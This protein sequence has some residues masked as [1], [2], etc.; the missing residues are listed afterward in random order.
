MGLGDELALINERYETTAA[1]VTRLRT[2]EDRYA[3]KLTANQLA[4]LG[5]IVGL[6]TFV[7]GLL[8]TG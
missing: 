7:I 6:V 2:A 8:V 5:I 3:V 1:E 4:V